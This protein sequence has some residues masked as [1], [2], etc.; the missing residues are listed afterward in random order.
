M[1]HRS[2]LFF[3]VSCCILSAWV[4]RPARVEADSELVFRQKAFWGQNKASWQEE[5]NRNDICFQ[6]NRDTIQQLMDKS[7]EALKDSRVGDALRNYHQ[8]LI[9][10]RSLPPDEQMYHRG[11]YDS[12]TPMNEWIPRRMNYILKDLDFQVTN[13]VLRDTVRTVF[14]YITWRDSPVKNL[15]YSYRMKDG[16]SG[17]IEADHGYGYL[18]YFGNQ[19]RNMQ[20]GRIKMEL[21]DEKDHHRRKLPSDNQAQGK[22]DVLS[23]RTISIPL[24][25]GQNKHYQRKAN[26]EERNVFVVVE[27]MPTFRG[28]GI[29]EFRQ[30]VQKKLHYPRKAREQKLEG[31]VFVRFTI[32]TDGE[33]SEVKIVRGV[34]PLLDKEALRVIWNSPSWKTGRQ[35]GRPVRVD[36]TLPVQ[37]EL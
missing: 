23:L 32:D 36:F 9:R 4:S 18:R 3:I 22:G 27:D 7:E 2:C 29:G 17:I 14:L 15:S 16:W 24:Q 5:N 28:G 19:S 20:Y 8:A 35:R 26:S 33:V 34:D 30:Y 25:K 21:E 37:F 6:T 10:I 12:R 1:K 31:V 13:E 11:R